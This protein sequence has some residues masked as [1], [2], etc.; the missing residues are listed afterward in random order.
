MSK[1]IYIYGA[2]G[3]AKVVAAA[4][5][6]CGY[7]IMGFWEDSTARVGEPFFGSNIVAFEDVPEGALIFIAFGN[8]KI[9]LQKGV[10]LASGFVFPSIFHPSAQIAEGVEIGCGCYFGANS[11]VDPNCKIGDFCIVNN[12]ANVSHDSILADGCHVC[13]GVNMAGRTQIGICTLIGVGSCIIEN[14][15]VGNNTIVGAGSTV[16][17]DIPS[18]VTAVG[19]PARV[20][21]AL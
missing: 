19:S 7:K 10:D 17:H 16:I 2:G 21:H 8:N 14:C 20:I 18:D 1:E 15:T 3:H 11:N 4:A 9:R 13:G 6:L 5:R 12:N